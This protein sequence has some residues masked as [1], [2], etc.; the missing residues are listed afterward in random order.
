MQLRRPSAGFSAASSQ[1]PAPAVAASTA[2]SAGPAASSAG[3]E[4]ASGHRTAGVHIEL[5]ARITTPATGITPYRMLELRA[6]CRLT[7]TFGTAT[8]WHLHAP[9]L[10]PP[11]FYLSPC[12]SPYPPTFAQMEIELERIAVE[13]GSPFPVLVLC[14]VQA[15]TD[16]FAHTPPLVHNFLISSMCERLLRP[17]CAV[18]HSHHRVCV[19]C[20]FLLP[21]VATHRSSGRVSM[22]VS[23]HS[24]RP[25]RRHS[26][27]RWRRRCPSLY[28]PS[29]PHWGDR[30]RWPGAQ[31]M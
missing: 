9:C 21:S 17:N 12:P 24:R 18:R 29:R 14:A 16:S 26:R 8:H 20:R 2:I 19:A 5:Q 6:M 4:L 3:D 13:G 31:G 11:L 1:V 7:I 30:P 28:P 10:A 23:M 22:P 27:L 25:V 15:R